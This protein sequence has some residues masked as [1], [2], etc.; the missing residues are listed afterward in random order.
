[1]SNSKVFSTIFA[2]IIAGMAIGIS[3]YF[4]GGW[5]FDAPD[6]DLQRAVSETGSKHENTSVIG[7]ELIDVN[8]FFSQEL[9]YSDLRNLSESISKLNPRE[10]H[11]LIVKSSTQPGTSRLHTVQQ[12][13]VEYLVQSTP[14]DALVSIAQMPENR[15]HAMLRIIFSY[16][17]KENLEQALTAATELTHTDRHVVLDTIFTARS[18]LSSEEWSTFAARFNFLADFVVREQE[19][20]VHEMLDQEPYSAIELL[21]SDEI[22]DEQQISVYREVVEKWFQ[23]QGM[24]IIP[25]LEDARLGGGIFD[26]LFEQVAGQDRRAAL[27]FFIEVEEFRRDRLGYQL[28]SSWVIEDAEEAF[29]AV[30]NLPKSNY[31]HSMLDSLVLNWARKDPHVVL[32]RLMEIPRSVRD[33]ALSAA[34][35]ELALDGP[36]ELLDRIST[37]RTVPGTN[38]DRAMQTVVR[39]WSTDAPKLALDWVQSNSKENTTNRTQLLREVLPKIALIEP[40]EAMTIAVDDF[41]SDYIGVNLQD[42][43]IRALLHADRFDTAI[44]L[45]DRVHEDIKVLQH[46]SVGLEL[47]KHDRLDDA[48]SLAESISDEERLRYFNNVASNAVIFGR[49][50][51][52]LEMIVRLPTADLQFD[53]AERLLNRSGAALDFTKEQL[54]T[55]RG[56]VSE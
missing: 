49:T 13:L 11:D 25:K 2:G 3:S 31:R 41:N 53:V 46:I 39:T 54:E 5:I 10:L 45:L 22:D 30:M 4:V 27:A 23:Q 47:V 56:F 50:S 15:R 42:Y 24:N 19:L 48:L 7:E 35:R 33:G 34:A 14:E 55:L 17:S 16:W 43:V 32:D 21:A 8:E 44:E 29:Q 9:K 18:D 6:S 38:V 1:M 52:V 37:L 28:L 51:E 40:E 26:E 12:I 36:K 20:L